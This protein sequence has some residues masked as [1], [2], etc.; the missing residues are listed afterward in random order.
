MG[1]SVQACLQR[2]VRQN[3]CVLRYIGTFT[4]T[5]GGSMISCGQT[6]AHRHRALG[7]LLHPRT[8]LHGSERH[9]FLQSKVPNGVFNIFQTVAA[10]PCFLSPVAFPAALKQFCVCFLIT[11]ASRAHALM[12]LPRKTWGHGA[13]ST[14]TGHCQ[15][16]VCSPASVSYFFGPFKGSAMPSWKR[17]MAAHRDH[18]GSFFRVCCLGYVQRSNLP[19][20]D[21]STS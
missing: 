15:G 21:V 12:P 6:K 5:L 13:C 20:E 16:P 2:L 3:T 10:A 8:C 4:V 9:S 1:L 14:N 19:I 18:P 7:I 17:K 11:S